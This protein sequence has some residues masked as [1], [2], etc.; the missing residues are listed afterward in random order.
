MSAATRR[1]SD[2]HPAVREFRESL[3]SVVDRQGAELRALGRRVDKLLA[4]ATSTP[5][6]EPDPRR[7]GDDEAEA[8]EIEAADADDASES[9]PPRA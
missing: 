5:P 9:V 8:P 3:E 6:P 2:Q 4:R 1:K 7:G